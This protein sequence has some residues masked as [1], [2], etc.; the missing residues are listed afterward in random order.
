[1]KKIVSICLALSMV[2]SLSLCAFADYEPCTEQ[3]D[4]E[5]FALEGPFEDIISGTSRDLSV[6]DE[7]WDLS[8]QD[9]KGT[10]TVVGIDQ[11]YSNYYFSPN[12]DNKINVTYTIYSDT[13]RPTSMIIGLYDV[14]ERRQT[15]ASWTSKGATR[16]GITESFNFINLNPSHY[17]AITFTAYFD[18]IS[19]DTVHGTA[20][21]RH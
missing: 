10:L 8:R 18:G 20:T 17:Y 4:V 2:L 15:S 13:G 6:P 12:S 19:R 7:F 5:E 21:I 11:L 3:A 1:M 9:Y 14:T 16:D